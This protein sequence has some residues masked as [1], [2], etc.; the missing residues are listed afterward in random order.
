MTYTARELMV[1]ANLLT[2]PS[3][4]TQSLSFLILRT[5]GRT[6]EQSLPRQL[7][8]SST[9]STGYSRL[10]TSPSV[11]RRY[12]SLQQKSRSKFLPGEAGVRFEP[13][14]HHRDLNL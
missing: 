2:I 9:E 7:I 5:H 4:P 12:F 10:L 6:N 14:I 13:L 3:P 11:G 1:R 8:C